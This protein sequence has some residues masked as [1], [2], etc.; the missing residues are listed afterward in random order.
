ME[1]E[2]PNVIELQLP[3]SEGFALGGS[4]QARQ[5]Y[6]EQL[7][8][9]LTP[10][11]IDKGALIKFPEHIVVIGSCFMKALMEPFV[12]TLGVYQVRQKIHFQTSSEKLTKEVIRDIN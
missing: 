11:I 2:L 10:E 8:D 3:P 6:D 12:K 1:T 5:I 4:D 9:Q 7:K